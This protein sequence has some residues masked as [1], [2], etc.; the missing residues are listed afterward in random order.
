[1]EEPQFCETADCGA[2]DRDHDSLVEMSI[3]VGAWCACQGPYLST[4]IAQIIIGSVAQRF[5]LWLLQKD[6]PQD[7]AD[8]RRTAGML[9]WDDEGGC[10][11]R[12]EPKPGRQRR[13][14]TLARR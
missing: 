4:H 10:I 11:C 14:L 2:V 13:S 5:V 3:N 9:W 7:R 8:R 1:M 6:R 12:A